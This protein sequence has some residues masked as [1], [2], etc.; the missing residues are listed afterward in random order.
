MHSLRPSETQSLLWIQ[1][2]GATTNFVS[3][4]KTYGFLISKKHH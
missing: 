2:S 1:S 4:Y 3:I